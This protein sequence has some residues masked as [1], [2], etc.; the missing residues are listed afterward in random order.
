MA[1]LERKKAVWR[2]FA[3]I[4]LTRIRNGVQLRISKGFDG[5]QLERVPVVP[6]TGRS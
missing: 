4:I 2:H 1:Q 5:Q 6:L 3:T